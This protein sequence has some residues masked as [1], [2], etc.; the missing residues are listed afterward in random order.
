MR[1][2]VCTRV[3]AC[4]LFACTCVY[5]RVCACVCRVCACVRVLAHNSSNTDGNII[6]KSNN[7][8]TIYAI[9]IDIVDIDIDSNNMITI[10]QSYNPSTTNNK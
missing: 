7:V 10:K 9:D 5:A 3:C 4:V 8:C 6:N 1:V 2:C